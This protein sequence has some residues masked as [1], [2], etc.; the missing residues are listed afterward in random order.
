MVRHLAWGRLGDQV[1][2]ATATN[3]GTARIWDP[4]SGSVLATLSGHTGPVMHLA[5]GRLGDQVVIATASW[6]GT[7]RIWEVV[8]ERFV[9]RL[10]PYRS[11]D[12]GD[13]DRL[14]R[15]PEA[16]AL[17]EV[18]TSRSALPPLAIGL[19]GDWGEG[20]S[21]FL[22]RVETHVRLIAE[23]AGPDDPLTHSAVRQVRFNAWHYA[24]SDLWASLVSEVF[25]RAAA[26]QADPG[27]AQRRQSRLASEL[28]DRRQ[29][30]ERLQAAR[31]RRDRLQSELAKSQHS[32][33]WDALPAEIRNEL[34]AAAGTQAQDLYRDVAGS[35]AEVKGTVSEIKARARAALRV[36]KAAAS[37]WQLW[38]AVALST[39]AVAAFVLG[40]RL[41]HYLA[42]VPVLAA[43]IA[44][45]RAA[46]RGWDA[47]KRRWD[48]TK[49]LRKKVIETLHKQAE[50]QR[51]R[52]ETASDV[53]AAEVMALETE[54][55]NLSTAGQLAG[56]VS[57]RAQEG[58]YRSRLG[59]MTQI[60]EDFERMAE[61]LAPP[62]GRAPPRTD[63]AGDEL[64]R[65]E[66]IVVYID[67]LDRCPPTRVIEVLEA[68]HLLLAV[69]LFVVVVAVDPR[70]LL[71]A[72]AVHY[73]ELLQ[74]D[75]GLALG[76]GDVARALAPFG[77]VDDRVGMRRDADAYGGE[78]GWATP[79]QY[80][81]KI[82]QIP[83][84]LPPLTPKGYASMIDWLVGPAAHPSD[85]PPEATGAPSDGSTS[86]R[87]GTGAAEPAA[88]GI[89]DED[90]GAELPTPRTVE[91][92]DPM[93]LTEDERHFRECFSAP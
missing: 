57:E 75:D 41:V 8:T 42:S 55:Q 81:E 51:W 35:W 53:A 82:F 29:L 88:D 32:R 31:Q 22:G 46:E 2:V 64:P 23:Q 59:L 21:H 30:R 54:I 85:A 7:A 80:L 90:A 61:L 50:G 72:V 71:R 13:L 16:I 84:T 12:P 86:G 1:V 40:P 47:T 5:W 93:E 56:M 63:A 73:R 69:R 9:A 3:D 33:A 68:V 91:R 6:D 10:P 49:D 36:V 15:D 70:W 74:T 79:A 27:G 76:G 25:A 62:A 34:Q 89:D 78:E 19:F 48:A 39:T 14:S 60:R 45:A 11:D 38:L 66:R 92:L 87:V 83:L 58:T 4:A 44:L 17:A 65:I 24:E 20:K 77:K 52:L 28:I 18:I 37:T 26:D 43:L 67:D